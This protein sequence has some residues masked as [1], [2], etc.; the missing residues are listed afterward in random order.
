MKV[1]IVG[2]GY[3][4]GFYMVT[5]PN[6]PKLE[7]IGAFDINGGR[8]D[9]FTKEYNLYKYSSLKE[10]L[11]DENVD[12][13]LNLTWI[14]SHYA[15]TKQALLAGK[16]VYSEKPI[17]YTL[18]EAEELVELANMKNLQLN[19]APCNFIGASGQTLNQLIKEEVIGKVLLVH[20][21]LQDGPVYLMGYENW[22]NPSGL[23][24]PFEEEFTMGCVYEHAGYYLSWLIHLFGSVVEVSAF[25]S[26]IIKEI[27][28]REKSLQGTDFCVAGLRHESGVCVHFICSS[29][30]PSDNSLRIIGEK[31]ILEVDDCWN[32]NSDVSVQLFTRIQ[33]NINQ[34]SKFILSEKKRFPLVEGLDYAYHYKDSHDMNFAA[35]VEELR[36]SIENGKKS[37]LNKELALHVLEIISV[38]EET[39]KTQSGS[40]RLRTAYSLESELVLTP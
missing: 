22:K 2:C 15:I 6:F 9:A 24:W 39:G 37:R 33:P 20:A 35:G 8:L 17:S 34:N 23:Q 10:L 30:S 1:A 21:S 11:Q 40:F 4:A 25:S 19:V 28:G 29:I 3:V 32:W 36:L 13:V 12:I 18:S 5:M 7:V 31:G 27:H 16:H 14:K 26:P 38:M